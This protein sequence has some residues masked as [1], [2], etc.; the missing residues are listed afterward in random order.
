VY[1]GEAY[2]RRPVTEVLADI[3]EMARSFGDAP[4]TAFLQDADPLAARPEDLLAILGR[5]RDRFPRLSR[6]TAYARS[7]T[8]ERRGLDDL[9]RL[10][11]AGLTRIHT[12]FE[13][14][15]DRVLAMVDKGATREH[16]LAAGR[17]A[18]EAGFALSVYVMPGLG[19]RGLSAEHADETASLV[20][21]TNPEFTRLRTTAPVGGTPLGEMVETGAFV[22]LS[23]EETV[24]EIRRFLAGLEAAA[25][26]IESDHVLNLL[27]HLRGDLPGDRGR[28]LAMCDEFLGLPPDE[29][30]LFVLGRRTGRLRRP[31]D[32]DQP[33]LRAAL[34][35]DL[36]ALEASG[37]TPESY[38]AILRR[39]LL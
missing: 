35:A 4:R 16:H 23:E 31:R 3:E 8:L 10:R 14:G 26:R 5:L 17:L 33:G 2:S 37:E 25:T 28:L 20:A 24:G 12:G 15:S 11:E 21:A 7:R 39:A 9:K 38:F 13:S 32:L 34:R 18:K 29:R 27:L 19:G 1:K 36:A 22:P 6:V 30:T